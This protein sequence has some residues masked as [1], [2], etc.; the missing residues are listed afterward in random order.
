M[1][2]LRDRE[3]F[4]HNRLVE[5]LASYGIVNYTI[6]EF[7]VIDIDGDVDLSSN[8]LNKLPFTFGK[9]TGNFNCGNNNL[10]KLTGSPREV[11][12]DFDCSCNSL[13]SLEGAPDEVGGD[14]DCSVNNLTSLQGS[15]A[16]VGGNFICSYNELNELDMVSNIKCNILCKGNNFWHENDVHF[17]GWC[18]GTI[19]FSDDEPFDGNGD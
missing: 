6:G 9:V 19:D 15:P 10:I 18:G 8:E 3:K 13:D 16:E 7:N 2:F 17:N 1:K 5:E 4:T 11:G 12:G 14:F